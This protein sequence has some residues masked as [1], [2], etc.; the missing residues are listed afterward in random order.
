[1]SSHLDTLAGTPK[2]LAHLVAEMDDATL[3]L[4]PG[5]GWSART[6]LAHFRDDE[7]LCMRPALE[8]MLAEERPALV[9]LDGALW[10]P[11]R[12]R[13]R[14]RKEQLLAGF[15]LQRQAALSILDALRPEDRARTGTWNGQA[16][17]VQQFLGH[18]AG[19]DREHLA[20]LEALAGE[21]ADQA[22]ERRA[23]RD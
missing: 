23:R 22:R 14:D 16:F 4:A 6:V 5:G 15:A 2:A 13:S 20:Q 9:F 12:N 7:Y 8:R 1:M 18:W 19:H 11:G 10:E 17:T 21:T 3:D